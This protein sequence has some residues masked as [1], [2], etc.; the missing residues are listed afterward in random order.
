MRI[1]RQTLSQV[2][3]GLLIGAPI[4]LVIGLPVGYVLWKT[5]P[6][7]QGETHHQSRTHYRLMVSPTFTQP[8][9]EE[10]RQ[11]AHKWEQAVGDPQTLTISVKVGDCPTKPGVVEGCFVSS[12]GLVDCTPVHKGALGCKKT[13]L[14]YDKVII[15]VACGDLHTLSHLSQHEIGHVIG[16]LDTSSHKDVMYGT[17]ACI[18]IQTDSSQDV[19]PSDVKEYLKLR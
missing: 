16:L 15:D 17:V 19:S 9:Q 1:Q 18:S 3:R 4:G 6:H 10:I 2:L 5:E 7:H 11:A 12:P 8:Q 13:T 14:N